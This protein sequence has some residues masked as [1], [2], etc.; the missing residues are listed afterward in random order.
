MPPSNERSASSIRRKSATNAY[1]ISTFTYAIVPHNAPQKG[2]L[3]Q[4]I[5]YA[6]T[7]GQKYGPALDFAP[8]P[9]VVAQRPRNT[10]ASL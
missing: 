6:I 10:I 8:L 4:F 3:Q 9:K 7:I 1:P 2:D 5:N